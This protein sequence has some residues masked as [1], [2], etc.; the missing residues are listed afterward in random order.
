NSLGERAGI[1]RSP[2][3]AIERNIAR[4]GGKTDQCS[5]PCLCG[6][7]AAPY[8]S[9]PCTEHAGKVPGERVVTTSI[10]EEDISLRLALHGALDE[11]KPDCLEVESRRSG[12][13][14]IDR[15]EVVY[16]RDLEAM[17][18]IMEDAGVSAG[19]RIREGKDLCVH[20]ALV[21]VDAEYDSEAEFP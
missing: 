12:Q 19:Q 5:D 10:E 3:G 4:L 1:G 21:E 8:L 17:A 11:I 14:C 20:R 18:R 13:L 6:G 16:A 7:Q 9:R 15:H 2:P